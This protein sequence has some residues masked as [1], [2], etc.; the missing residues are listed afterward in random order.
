M[1]NSSY[2]SAKSKKTEHILTVFPYIYMKVRV[3]WK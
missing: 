3:R 1:Q 2:A